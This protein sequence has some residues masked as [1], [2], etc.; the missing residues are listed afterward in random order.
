MEKRKYTHWTVETLTEAAKEYDTV[1][2]FHIGNAGAYMAAKR[3]GL[4]K[5]V[6]AHMVSGKGK[7]VLWGRATIA[8]EALKYKTRTEFAHGSKAAYS[9]ATKLKIIDEVCGHMPKY[10]GKGKVRGKNA[11][12]L[13][14]HTETKPAKTMAEMMGL[15]T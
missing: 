14:K 1:N 13:A 12:G 6:T 7:R 4:F 2:A 8:A 5:A 11:R 10:A 9:A 3:K 15:N